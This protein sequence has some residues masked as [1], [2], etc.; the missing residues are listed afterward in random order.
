MRGV[1]F[2]SLWFS[3]RFAI[4]VAVVCLL[5]AL[6][7]LMLSVPTGF[8]RAKGHGSS[9]DPITVAGFY[10]ALP[11][12]RIEVTLA[13]ENSLGHQVSDV[14]IKDMR[15][16]GSSPLSPR[17]PIVISRLSPGEVTHH[18][19]CFAPSQKV[20]GKPVHG[21]ITLKFRTTFGMGEGFVS[22]TL[23]VYP[24]EP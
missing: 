20:N 23:I 19:L 24:A 11:N 9:R 13:I 3:A 10:R 12:N 8:T 14:E 7:G 6:L 17:L 2:T 16:E 18:S 4:G 21:E 15:L 1:L 5:I 22:R